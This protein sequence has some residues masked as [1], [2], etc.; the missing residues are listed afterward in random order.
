[1][2]PIN[3]KQI[4]EDNF[5]RELISTVCGKMYDSTSYDMI[6]GDNAEEKKK[7][8]VFYFYS[9][10]GDGQFNKDFFINYNQ[11][12]DDIINGNYDITPRAAII[13]SGIS[14]KENELTNPHTLMK[15]NKLYG[16]ENKTYISN[17]N[18][19]PITVNFKVIHF[20]STLNDS[21]RYFQEIINQKYKNIR[22][23]WNYMTH[24]IP[25]NISIEFPMDID[26]KEQLTYGAD[27][28]FRNNFTLKVDTYYPIIDK[29][30]EMFMGTTMEQIM[31]SNQ[32]ETSEY[33]QKDQSVPP[34]DKIWANSVDSGLEQAMLNI[35]VDK[36]DS[37]PD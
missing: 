4:F 29:S 14:F 26:K 31:S 2:N 8:N 36:N 18:T 9:D 22:Y 28:L 23:K 21:L 17:I 13:Y 27:R 37:N 34:S 6:W 19:L 30:K 5:F 20:T 12:K 33:Y 16:G 3:D 15:Y 24:I 32:Y 10:T 7:I 11:C 35:N 25:S 1:M